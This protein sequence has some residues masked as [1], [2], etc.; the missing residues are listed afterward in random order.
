[1]ENRM[2]KANSQNTKLK[3]KEL[4]IGCKMDI[5]EIRKINLTTTTA[6]NL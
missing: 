3:W 5:L 1:M 4:T 2:E 6:F